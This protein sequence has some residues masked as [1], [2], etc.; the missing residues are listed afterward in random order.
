MKA[1]AQPTT[2][3]TNKLIRDKHPPGSSLPRE[4]DG[5]DGLLGWLLADVV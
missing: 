1:N 3:S 2:I 5:D 4:G